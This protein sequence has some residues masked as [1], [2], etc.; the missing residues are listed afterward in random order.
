MPASPYD[1]LGVSLDAEPEVVD[2]AY[3]A[4]MKKY[5]PDRGRGQ[6]A[7]GRE[8]AQAI[9]AAYD[10]IKGG[11]TPPAPSEAMTVPG[12]APADLGAY[13]VAPPPVP[14]GRNLAIATGITV[15]LL[16]LATAIANGR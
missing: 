7:E 9:N 6:P 14:A 2:A 16:A 8:R 10:E 3:R 13:I 4:L 12:A 15:V 11:I 1:V 5:H